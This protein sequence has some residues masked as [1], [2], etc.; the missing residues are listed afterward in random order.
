MSKAVKWLIGI[1]LVAIVAVGSFFVFG[2]QGAKKDNAKIGKFSVAYNNPKGAIKGGDLKVAEVSATPFQ[3]SFLAPLQDDNLTQEIFKPTGNSALFYTDKNFKII[4]GGPANIK[5]DRTNKTAT[6]KL[7]DK[8][9]WSDG[10]PVTAKDVELTYELIANNAYGSDRWSSS[11]ANI[12][13]LSEYHAGKTDTIS[14]ITYPDGENGKTLKIAFKALTP[15]M[16]N[17]G[18]GYFLETATPYHQI[19]NIKPKDLAASAANTTKPLS[20]GP[21]TVKKV[22]AGQS[23]LFAPNPHYYGKAPQLKSISTEILAPTKAVAAAKAHKFD[24]ID[25]ATA[26]LYPTLKNVS[27]YA[28][29]GNQDLYISLKYFNLGHYDEA[30]SVNVQDRDTPLQDKKVRQALAYALNIDEIDNTV[31]NGVKS[32]AT[33]LI[34]ALFSTWHDKTAKGFP[35]DIKK[36]KALLDEA[37][38]QVDKKTGYRTKDGKEL[39]LVYLSRSGQSTSEAIAQNNIQQWKKVGV[40]VTL[41]HDRLQDFNTWAKL[42]Q[43]NDKE[44]DIT[45]AAWGLSSEPSQQDLFSKEAAF[46][47][48]HFTS[49]ELTAALNAIDSQKAL[50]TAYRKKAFNQYQELMN[51]EAYVIPDSYAYKYTPV[52]KRV[53]GWSDANGDNELWNK[54]GVSSDTLATK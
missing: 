19:K 28:L 20:F 30:N 10:Q 16:T 14:G 7:Q 43:S 46:N 45:D 42:V 39:S 12:K 22:V 32:R 37:G 53:V 17:S 36:A 4:D 40:K 33:T 34:P 50:D 18:N 49:D 13:G 23:V 9:T 11:L 41:Y 6:I 24:V 8:L 48:G 35:N 5:F 38:W 52:N 2:N 54:L 44:W 31:L 21:W 1:V 3:G 27:G 51:Q 26:D 25:Q 29:T 47:Y 15:G